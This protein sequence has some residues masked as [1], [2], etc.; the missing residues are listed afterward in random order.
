MTI[1]D[2]EPDA[3]IARVRIDARNGR[4]SKLRSKVY[5]D[6]VLHGGDGGAPIRLV[7]SQDD[8]DL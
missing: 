8:S 2:T 4:Q 5:G 1:A 7:I 3:A 6:K